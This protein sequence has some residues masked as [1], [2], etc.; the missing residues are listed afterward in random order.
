MIE[1][2]KA[3]LFGSHGEQAGTEEQPVMSMEPPPEDRMEQLLDDLNREV[4]RQRTAQ[5]RGFIAT[6]K[7]HGL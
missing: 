7:R 4:A 3:A 5:A 6:A 2:I 1:R